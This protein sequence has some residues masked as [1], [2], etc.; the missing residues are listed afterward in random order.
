VP[1]Q[2]HSVRAGAFTD[3]ATGRPLAQI[4]DQSVSEKA[5]RMATPAASSL[6]TA[7]TITTYPHPQPL[8][9]TERGAGERGTGND[10]A[11]KDVVGKSSEQAV[12]PASSPLSVPERGRG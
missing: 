2:H 6:P 4:F 5:A 1:I 12:E 8:S 9:E 11:G 3:E 7:T 10:G